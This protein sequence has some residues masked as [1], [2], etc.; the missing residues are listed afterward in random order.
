[1]LN[2]IR[3]WFSLRIC[4]KISDKDLLDDFLGV[5]S[6]L[7]TLSQRYMLEK[8]SL[9]SEGVCD[10]KCRSVQSHLVVNGKFDYSRVWRQKC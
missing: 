6:T 1:M 5:E 9:K 10:F 2:L 7:T 4:N 8:D 3:V